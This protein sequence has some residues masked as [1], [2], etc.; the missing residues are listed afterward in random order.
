MPGCP[1][2]VHARGACHD[3]GQVLG[4]EAL[5]NLWV[6]ACGSRVRNFIT[7]LGQEQVQYGMSPKRAT[8]VRH[9]APLTLVC[10]LLSAPAPPC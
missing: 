8:T 5:C 7:K 10:C 6:G 3:R 4:R 2:G 1:E 9:A